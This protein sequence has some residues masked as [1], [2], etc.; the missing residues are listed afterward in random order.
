M[1]RLGDLSAKSITVDQIDALL[2]SI[3]SA[4]VSPRTVNKTRQLICAVFN[5]G[6]RPKTWALQSNPAQA[7][8]RRREGDRAVVAFYTADQIEELARTLAAGAH[9][10]LG[11]VGVEV[12]EIEAQ[13]SEDAQDG[14]IVRLA[15]YAGLR[16]GELVALRWRDVDLPARKITVRRTVSGGKELASTK[17]RRFREVPIPDQA[18]VPLRRLGNRDDFTGPDDYIFVNRF[19]R[20]IDPSAL[21][22]RYQRARETTTLEPL[23]FH[24]LRHAYG[25]L[26]VAGGVDLVS[27]KAAMDTPA[28]RR[29]SATCTPDRPA[30]K[31]L[32]SPRRSQA[33][34][35]QLGPAGP[36]CGRARSVSAAAAPKRLVDRTP[37]TR[38]R[39]VCRQEI[40]GLIP[41]GSIG[42]S[43]GN[44]LVLS[45]RPL[46]RTSISGLGI[47]I[48]HQIGFEVQPP[49]SGRAEWR[50]Q[51][52][53]AAQAGS[54]HVPIGDARRLRRAGCGSAHTNAMLQRIPPFLASARKDAEPPSGGS[55]AF[56]GRC[57][58]PGGL[59]NEP[60]GSVIVAG[61]WLAVRG[62]ERIGL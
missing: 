46:L 5:Y 28:S 1:A 39:Q 33:Q 47:R 40:A 34:P 30:N 38:C 25:S 43:P 3:A 37:A 7:S 42:R 19:G 21:R 15:A 59:E 36:R 54:R 62:P 55:S 26:L 53:P 44:H 57:Y 24:D 18:L 48:G 20:R 56:Q 4:D 35:D 2:T 50:H 13:A 16:R 27:V 6:M 9:R 14:E 51:H 23:R 8:D 11:R 41:A 45:A 10:D 29:P 32:S 22:R 52:A 58:Q 49:N 60:V 12:E 17:G 31:P 61:N